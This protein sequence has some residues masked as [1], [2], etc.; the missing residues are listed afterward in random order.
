MALNTLG[1]IQFK[2]GE[3]TNNEDKIL[4]AEKN[5]E[6]AIKISSKE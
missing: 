3:I 2:Q 6:K 4:E 5:F 1:E